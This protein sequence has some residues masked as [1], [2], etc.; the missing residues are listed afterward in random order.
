MK[1]KK[2]KISKKKLQKITTTRKYSLEHEGCMINTGKIMI[3]WEFCSFKYKEQNCFSY[4]LSIKFTNKDHLDFVALS[5]C[6]KMMA[7]R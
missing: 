2:I 6:Q 5:D 4:F 1:K 3:C 7:A